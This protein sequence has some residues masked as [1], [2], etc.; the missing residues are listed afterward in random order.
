M[1]MKFNTSLVTE[2]NVDLA[3]YEATEE[4]TAAIVAAVTATDMNLTSSSSN[5]IDIDDSH[6]LGSTTAILNAESFTKSQKRMQMVKDTDSIVDVELDE[7]DEML[8]VGMEIDIDGDAAFSARTTPTR[9]Q[10]HRNQRKKKRPRSDVDIFG[11]STNDELR[12]ARRRMSGEAAT[13]SSNNNNNSSGNHSDD[14]IISVDYVNG[15]TTTVPTT[16]TMLNGTYQ[17]ADA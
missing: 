15:H 16:T 7:T 2:A 3:S 12:V 8:D 5:D 1:T 17:S 11:T 13:S 10:Q 4:D 6:A 14:E 9:H